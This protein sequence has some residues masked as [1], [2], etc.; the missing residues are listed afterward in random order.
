MLVLPHSSKLWIGADDGRIWVIDGL[1][2]TLLGNFKA[3]SQDW[4]VTAL[5]IVGREV[6]SASE[7]CLA[8]H[9]LETGERADVMQSGPNRFGVNGASCMPP[10]MGHYV[11]VWVIDGLSEIL[12]GSFNPHNQ[13]WAVTA[14]AVVGREVWSASERCLAVHD[15][16]TGGWQG[17]GRG[18]RGC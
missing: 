15:I 3:H 6:W 14:L 2:E 7:R 1:S 10:N 4:A 11:C 9:D 18:G 12:L 5:A 16:E 17:A 13:D 8:V